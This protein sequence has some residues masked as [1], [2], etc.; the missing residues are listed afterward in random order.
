M[1]KILSNR[2][3][4]LLLLG[5]LDFSD[6]FGQNKIGLVMSDGVAY[7]YYSTML[8]DSIRNTFGGTGC[9]FLPTTAQ[10]NS[11]HTLVYKGHVVI[12]A[13]GEN[14]SIKLDLGRTSP[15]KVFEMKGVYKTADKSV[16]PDWQLWAQKVAQNL[17][18]IYLKD[19]IDF[20]CIK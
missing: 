5:M 12:N 4:F 2:F 7:N 14:I 9:E 10:M 15:D 13:E 8:M 17:Y 20:P 16:R 19:D 1:K 6:S 18:S 3:Y 11:H